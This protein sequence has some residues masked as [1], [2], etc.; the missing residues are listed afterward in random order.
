MSAF[1]IIALIL[2]EQHLQGGAAM[3]TPVVFLLTHIVVVLMISNAALS[4]H[5][6][7]QVYW[8]KQMRKAL[9]N[10]RVIPQ[11]LKFSRNT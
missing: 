9:T 3:Q 1:S 8:W 4:G 6:L 5:E 10:F 7:L 11:G 2:R